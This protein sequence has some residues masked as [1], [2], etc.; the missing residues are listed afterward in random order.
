MITKTEK[1]SRSDLC[2]KVTKK[3]GAISLGVHGDV[4]NNMRNKMSPK[5]PKAIW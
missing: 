1:F 3:N 5:E 2:V 4:Y